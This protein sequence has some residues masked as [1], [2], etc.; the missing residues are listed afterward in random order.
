MQGAVTAPAGR[1]NASFCSC[2]HGAL[3]GPYCLALEALLKQHLREVVPGIA[4]FR[5]V[6]GGLAVTPVSSN[7]IE[8]LT[9][10]ADAVYYT[11]RQSSALY[12]LPVGGTPTPLGPFSIS[13]WAPPE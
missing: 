13:G 5:M 3:R 7:Y 11:D 1:R 2:P 4:G 9:A 12:R 6:G 10:D 8:E